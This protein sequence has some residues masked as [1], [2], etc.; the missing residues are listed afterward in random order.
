[1]AK[2][3]CLV[4]FGIRLFYCQLY[5]HDYLWFSSYEVSKVSSTVPVI[6]N[7]ALSYSF[8]DFSYGI[9]KGSVPRYEEDLAQFRLYTTPA[10]GED[11]TRTKITYN[12]LNAKTLRTDDAP[13]AVNSPGLG[14]RVYINP[15]YKNTQKQAGLQ[16]YMFTFDGSVPKGITRLG[17]K[18][19]AIRAK[20]EEINNPIACHSEEKVRPTHPINPLDISGQVYSYDPIMLPPHM[21]FRTAEIGQDWFVFSG[22]HRVHVPIRVRYRMER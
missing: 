18:G 15:V 21:L 7:Y 2:P 12:A 4:D 19:A 6:H 11:C 5:N 10:S 20:W 16:C 1:M 22:Q 17:K 14:R 8:S 9:F 13:K 3:Y